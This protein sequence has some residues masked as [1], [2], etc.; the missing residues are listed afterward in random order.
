MSRDAAKAAKKTS[1]S[2]A[3]YAARQQELRQQRLNILRGDSDAKK[4]TFPATN[5]I[6][7][8]IASY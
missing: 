7:Y 1:N 6:Q 3:E 2:S 4:R 5:Q 8:V